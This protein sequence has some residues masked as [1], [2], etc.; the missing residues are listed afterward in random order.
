[1]PLFSPRVGHLHLTLDD[2][3]WARAD[4]LPRGEHKLK[5]EVVDA[6]GGVLTAG[7]ITFKSPG[8]PGK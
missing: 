4:S 8:K 3:P 5:I 1:L 7:S 6:A 2:L